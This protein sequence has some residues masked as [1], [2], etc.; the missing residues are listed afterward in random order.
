MTQPYREEYEDE[1]H[2]EESNILL[3]L[4]HCGPLPDFTASG[5]K[6]RRWE[7]IPLFI[8]QKRQIMESDTCATVE[9]QKKVGVFNKN[10]KK[11][12]HVGNAF[13][14][15]FTC[16]PCDS[17]RREV[18]AFNAVEVESLL[19]SGMADAMCVDEDGSHV[20]YL[21]LRQSI[22]ESDTVGGDFAV[23]DAS[24]TETARSLLKH[25]A[26]IACLD[27]IKQLYWQTDLCE[28]I[29]DGETAF[30]SL[31]LSRGY[32]FLFLTNPAIL[33]ACTERNI[34]VLTSLLSSRA[35]VNESRRSFRGRSALQIC[36]INAWLPGVSV[37][38]KS[39]A[40]LEQ[41][42]AEGF[43]ALDHTAHLLSYTRDKEC[44]IH[45]FK[46]LLE[47]GASV[48]KHTLHILVA[49][50]DMRTSWSTYS[51]VLTL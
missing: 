1:A 13:N 34:T 39:S 22:R 46:L 45:I 9:M 38:L 4:S 27:P 5:R 51:C 19:S 31:M 3:R 26:D 42:D 15:M 44:A 29:E 37:L 30:V 23:L 14:D 2:E 35:N 28:C 11:C 41:T 33:V 50:Q 48:T 8:K 20:L 36:I 18:Q 25:G 17:L 12:R 21:L 16:I 10:R 43:T 32:N 49:S 40:L 24:K 6:F 7:R 47:S